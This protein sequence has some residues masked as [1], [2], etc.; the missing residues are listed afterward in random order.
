[1]TQIAQCRLEGDCDKHKALITEMSK[2]VGNSSYGRMITSKEKP[3]DIVYV[4]ESEISTKIID[5]HFY[6][7]TEL[8][9]GYYKVESI[10]ITDLSLHVSTLSSNIYLVQH[11]V[12]S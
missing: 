6:D 11:S 5:N 1:M 10:L 3:Y 2:L 9:D 12:V 4:D 7:M 8:P